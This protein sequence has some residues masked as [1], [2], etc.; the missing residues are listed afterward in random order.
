M[1]TPDKQ[2]TAY[3]VMT[4]AAD[5]IGELL[6][7]LRV[8][9]GGLANVTAFEE[10]ARYIMGNTNFVITREARNIVKAAIAKALGEAA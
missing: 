10:D 1:A 2:D 5:T 9:D 4:R 6:E 3:A 7:A 8:A